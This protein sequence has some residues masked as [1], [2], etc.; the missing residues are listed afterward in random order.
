MTE[1]PQEQASTGMAGIVGRSPAMEKL[2]QAVRRV[3]RSKATVL[4]RGA[5][6]TGKEMVAQAIHSNSGMSASR[7]VT[8]DCTSIPGTLMESELFGHERGA[9]TDAKT[10]KPGLLETA[11]GGTIFLDE[12]GLMPIE[13]QAKLLHVLETHRFRRLGGIKEI[14]VNVRF[15][16]ATNEDLETAVNEGRF[17]DDLYYRL[18]VV[19]IEVPA[20][21]ERGE[22]V[23]L[24]AEHFLQ[25]FC[26]MHGTGVRRL[27]DNTRVLLSSYSWPGNVRE[28]RNVIERAVLMTDGEFV[29]A[30]D[31]IIDRRS[32]RA[33]ASV[34]GFRIDFEDDAA[35]VF[36]FQGLSLE[37]IEKAIIEGVLRYTEGNVSRAAELLEISRDTL[38]YRIGK[39]D[40]ASNRVDS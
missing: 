9:F 24:I 29:R 22:D 5:S 6:G 2:L 28:L 3:A 40:V 25:F 7:F 14:A 31:L 17:R 27:T 12:I 26:E 4:I 11:D 34:D 1:A 19:P 32:K 33:I 30:D 15:L 38:R 13:L 18:N 10:Q 21:R 8:V 20:L 37:A 23:V 36:P 16:A 35:F 39:Y